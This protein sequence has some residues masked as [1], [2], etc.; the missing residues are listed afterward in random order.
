LNPFPSE[1]QALFK[2]DER[3]ITQGG[4][5]TL[6]GSTAKGDI[7]GAWR[8]I[9]HPN[10]P[11]EKLTDL[12]DEKIQRESLSTSDVENAPPERHART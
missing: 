1:P 3:G 11:S 9:F 12:R 10:I 8:R 6:D 7:S 2:L 5:S 4:L